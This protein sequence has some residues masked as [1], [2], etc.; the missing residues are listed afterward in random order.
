MGTGQVVT[1]SVGVQARSL[2]PVWG[3]RPGRYTQCGGTGQVVTP[4]VGV[5]ARSL[6]P[7]WGY[8][9]HIVTP[10][11]EVEAVITPSPVCG[12]RPHHYTQCGG[13]GGHY[14]QSSMWVQAISLHPVWGNRPGRYTQC[15]GT[16]QV[17]AH[18][19]CVRGGTGQVVTPRVGVQATYRYTQCGGTGQVVTLSVCGGGFDVATWYVHVHIADA[20]HRYRKMLP[21]VLCYLY[22]SHVEQHPVVETKHKNTLPYLYSYKELTYMI[23]YTC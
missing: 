5:Q 21:R 8:R 2:H 4:S 22:I 3:Y 19:E 1:S 15:G 20:M 23:F 16:V 7:V 11:V 18:S 10:S 12:Y 6:H 13:R 17:V 14:T 9:P